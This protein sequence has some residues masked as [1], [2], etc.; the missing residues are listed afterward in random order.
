MKTLVTRLMLYWLIL[1]LA[2][3]T[4]MR[5]VNPGQSHESLA[6]KDRIVVYEKSG[7]VIDMTLVRIDEHQIVGSLT[8]APMTSVIID[9]DDVEKIEVEAIDGGKTTLA[10]VGGI[11]LLPL[12][13]LAAF[14]GVMSGV[15]STV[16]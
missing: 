5:A 9:L 15:E 13:I 14:M 6:L 3:C 4:S 8:N 16:N 7:R 10:V 1:S 2:G 11:I 12:F